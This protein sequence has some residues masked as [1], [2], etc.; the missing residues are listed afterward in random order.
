[1]I[2][3]YLELHRLGFAT[4]FECT[5][6]AGRLAGGIYGVQ[7]GRVFFGE[8]MFSRAT[9]AS[10]VALAAVAGAADIELIDCQLSN[11]HLERMGAEEIPRSRFR[12][13]IARLGAA[14]AN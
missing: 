2:D 9:D 11:P 14:D 1:M 4:S 10:K 13:L 7:L 5:D 6:E 8:S 3:A 12:A